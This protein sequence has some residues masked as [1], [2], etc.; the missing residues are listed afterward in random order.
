M[1][2]LT[3][4]TLAASNWFIP[5][6]ILKHA[7]WKRTPNFP[8]LMAGCGSA[9]PRGVLS[10][11]E[12]VRLLSRFPPK[13]FKAWKAKLSFSCRA[14]SRANFLPAKSRLAQLRVDEQ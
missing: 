8:T 12:A 4:L 7:L 13:R 3:A 1:Q 6:L 9:W 10:V 2:F 14:Q 5:S 11:L